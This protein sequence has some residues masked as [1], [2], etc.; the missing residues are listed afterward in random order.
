MGLDIRFLFNIFRLPRWFWHSARIES[1]CCRVLKK[2]LP[3]E[4]MKWSYSHRLFS[5]LCFERL[6]F[7]IFCLRGTRSL[8]IASLSTVHGGRWL[9]SSP[10]TDLRRWEFSC[11]L[12]DPCWPCLLCSLLSFLISSLSLFPSSSVISSAFFLL[13]L[14][15]IM[16]ST[17]LPRITPCTFH[18]Y[19][20]LFTAKLVLP[21]A[22]HW[23]INP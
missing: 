10:F 17:C 19:H 11:Y 15:K 14:A 16:S 7:G 5:P 3:T 13:I 21:C 1:H 22:S 8:L 23:K 18:S 4:W 20:F 2:Y 9:P 6:C 12:S